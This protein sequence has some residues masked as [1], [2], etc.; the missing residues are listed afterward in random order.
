MK[1]ILQQRF[2]ERLAEALRLS[3]MTQSELSRA[4]GVRPQYVHNYLKGHDKE[5]GLATV[6]RFALALGLPPE[7]LV[8]T[9]DLAEFF[10]VK[11]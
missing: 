1:L 9:S 5:P 10:T 6:E 3:G 4:M 8:D 11:A 7:A 2:R